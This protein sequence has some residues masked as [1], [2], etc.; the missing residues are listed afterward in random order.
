MFTVIIHLFS[1]VCAVRFSLS[2]PYSLILNLI[3]IITISY[4][5]IRSVPAPLMPHHTPSTLDVHNV[6][7][8]CMLE[9]GRK[10]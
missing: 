7:S 8:Y 3:L 4:K 1:S 9:K 6:W 5:Y 10:K 2:V